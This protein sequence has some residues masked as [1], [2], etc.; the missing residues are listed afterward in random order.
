[1]VQPSDGPGEEEVICIFFVAERMP[2][3]L[4]KAAGKIAGAILHFGPHSAGTA[5]TFRYLYVP[6][7]KFHVRE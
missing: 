5:Q 1:L 2:F 4:G 7:L 6:A 3:W